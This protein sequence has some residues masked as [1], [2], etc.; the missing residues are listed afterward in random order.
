MTIQIG[1]EGYISI[2]AAANDPDECWMIHIDEYEKGGKSEE[3]SK[4]KPI[5]FEF[6]KPRDLMTLDRAIK[7]EIQSIADYTMVGNE[8]IVGKV[9]TVF[10]VLEYIALSALGVHYYHMRVVTDDNSSLKFRL[11][12]DILEK[13]WNIQLEE[14]D[15]GDI[16]EKTKAEERQ[17]VMQ[18]EKLPEEKISTGEA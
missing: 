5:D 13:N 10:E 12:H 15:K 9:F 7:N 6:S 17:N 8:L 4:F 3:P 1:N 11:S 14:F 2:R 16:I 18:E